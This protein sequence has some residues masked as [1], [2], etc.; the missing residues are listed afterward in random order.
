MA[1]ALHW[2]KQSDPNHIQPI[3]AAVLLIQNP[4]LLSDFPVQG[5]LL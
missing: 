4:V 2:I 3:P 5:A 1:K